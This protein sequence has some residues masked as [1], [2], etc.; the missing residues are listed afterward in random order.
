ME[1]LCESM[2]HSPREAVAEEAAEVTVVAVAT[3]E[4]T[5]AVM[6]IVSM[7]GY[8]LWILWKQLE[9]TFGILSTGGGYGGGGGYSGGTFVI[10]V[11]SCE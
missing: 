4:A 5:V 7:A 3:E 9:L 11:V 10:C 2:K 6:M 1:G 8:G